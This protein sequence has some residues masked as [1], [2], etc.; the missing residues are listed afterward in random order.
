MPV[1]RS[2]VAV[3]LLALLLGACRGEGE[4]EPIPEPSSPRGLVVQERALT[5]ETALT[6]VGLRPAPGEGGERA[7]DYLCEHSRPISLE[8][9]WKQR[10]RVTIMNRGMEM[11]PFSVTVEQYGAD[12]AHSGS[13]SLGRVL[14]P[15][16]TEK[17]FSG[18][19]LTQTPPTEILCRIERIESEEM[20]AKIETPASR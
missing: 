10:F 1:P 18:Y 17:S 9:G 19:L 16:L 14:V 8:N 2:Q 5:G 15:P 11:T 12:Q 3:A 6:A 13:R 20:T 7:W 4:V